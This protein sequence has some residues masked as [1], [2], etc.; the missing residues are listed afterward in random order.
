MPPL[1]CLMPAFEMCWT[2]S[3]R[4]AVGVVVD[5]VRQQV[6]PEACL[7]ISLRRATESGLRSPNR[8]DIHIEPARD[9]AEVGNPPDAGA[10]LQLLRPPPRAVVRFQGAPIREPEDVGLVRVEGPGDGYA[11][12]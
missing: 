11:Q 4:Q 1:G 9:A 6:G 8:S 3:P 7:D 2:A 12:F 5:G 10:E